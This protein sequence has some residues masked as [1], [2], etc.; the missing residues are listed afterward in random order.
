MDQVLICA[1]DQSFPAEPR[2]SQ[3]DCEK[4]QV[5]HDSA[6]ARQAAHHVADDSWDFPVCALSTLEK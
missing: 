5:M 3:G 6:S 1:L 2:L 4:I